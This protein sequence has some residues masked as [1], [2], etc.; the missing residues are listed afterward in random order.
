MK[1]FRFGYL[2]R[3]DFSHGRKKDIYII[4]KIN[5]PVN[6]ILFFLFLTLK[7]VRYSFIRCYDLLG[8]DYSSLDDH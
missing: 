6:K 3:K 7:H 5:S 4:I 2:S 8:P 1:K